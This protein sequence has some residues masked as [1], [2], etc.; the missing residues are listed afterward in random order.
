MAVEMWESRSD[1]QGVVGGEGKPAFG[2]PSPSTPRHFRSLFG[3]RAFPLCEAGKQLRLSSLHFF[4]GAGIALRSGDLFRLFDGEIV[5][6]ISGHSGQLSKDLP[7]CCVPPVRASRLALAVLL[8]LR[9][10]AGPVKIQIAVEVLLIEGI[11][12]V[13]MIG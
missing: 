3:S 12:V 6:Q 1:F 8:Q 2:F 11:D 4:C 5:L 9:N 10:S 7:W 13:R